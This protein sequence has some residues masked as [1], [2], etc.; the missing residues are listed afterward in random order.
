[1]VV[2]SQKI[3]SAQSNVTDAVAAAAIRLQEAD[4]DQDS[5]SNIQIVLAE[6]LNNI[7]EHAYLFK[8]D[9]LIDLTLT[10]NAGT[11]GIQLKDH[12]CP[13]PGVPPVK[14]MM[15]NKTQFENLPEGGFGWFMIH[16]LTKSIAYSFCEGDNI[17]SLEIAAPYRG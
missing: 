16:S 11:L 15:G 12:G 10:L 7:V 17:L 9:G 6:A 1:M 2:F 3:L 8:E 5:I 4:V 14:M 13:F